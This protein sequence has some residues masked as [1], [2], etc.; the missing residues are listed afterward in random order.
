MGLPIPK[1]NILFDTD[2]R[3]EMVI[4]R[5]EFVEEMTKATAQGITGETVWGGPIEPDRPSDFP[6]LHVRHDAKRTG[7]VRKALDDIEMAKGVYD[8]TWQGSKSEMF[9]KEWTLGFRGLSLAIR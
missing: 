8:A 1:A 6:V 2:D 4:R 7:E 5:E 9:S 3:R